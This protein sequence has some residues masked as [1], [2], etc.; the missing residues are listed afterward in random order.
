MME[1]N[2][3]QIKFSNPDIDG[4]PKPQLLTLE[5]ENPVEGTSERE[6]GTPYTWHKWLCTGNQY[7]MASSALDGML[8]MTPDKVGKVI[9]IEKVENPNGEHPFFQVNGMNRDQILTGVNAQRVNTIID[10]G[11]AIE[12]IMPQ[13]I[14]TQ[15]ATT[16]IVIDR[17]EQKLDRIITMLGEKLPF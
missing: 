1:D 12:P 7:F 11:Q 13:T 10:N 6:D 2:R 9:K 17:V 4:S 16:D 15:P 14:A 3:I 5:Q 8:K